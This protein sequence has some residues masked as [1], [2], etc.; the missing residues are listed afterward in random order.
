MNRDLAK[1]ETPSLDVPIGVVLD[2]NAAL[3][4]F[5]WRDPDAGELERLWRAGMIRFLASPPC[6]GEF[7]HVL[8][9]S[10]FADD[11]RAPPALAAYHAT[12]AVIEPDAPLMHPPLPRCS[13]RS[14]QKFLEAALQARVPLLVS[15]DKALRILGRRRHALPFAILPPGDAGDWLCQRIET[16][17][18]PRGHSRVGD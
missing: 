13:D 18:V 9:R 12:V 5:F 14:D 17:A 15:R 1:V 10:P 11:V 4:L 7:A 8:R 16:S 2:T 6:L 3:D